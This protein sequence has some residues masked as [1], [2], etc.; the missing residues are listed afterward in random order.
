MMPLLGALAC[1]ALLAWLEYL[2]RMRQ[3]LRPHFM[4]GT[5][6]WRGDPPTGKR[7]DQG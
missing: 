1:G 7:T 4:L 6:H 5:L 3:H 2:A